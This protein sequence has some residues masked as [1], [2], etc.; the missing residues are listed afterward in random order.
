[1]RVLGLTGSVGSGKSHVSDYLSSL[2]ARIVD[3]D[4]ISH[5]LTAPGGSALPD[6]RRVF[7]DSVFHSDGTLN[8]KALAG[9][10]FSSDD[11]RSQL[12]AVIQPMILDE[13]H[14]QMEKA[15]TDQ[16]P[17]CVLD[18]PLLFEEHLDT[19]C[20]SIWCV[21]LPQELQ[22]RRI[23]ERDGCSAS[24]ALARI[25]AQMD[26]REKANRSHVVID[27]S[28]TFEETDAQVLPC[29]QRELRLSAEKGDASYAGTACQ[30]PQV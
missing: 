20:D 9:I 17:V 23:M 8:R 2:G 5:A 14:A 12:N 4:K 3:G 16:C 10:V 19:L 21:Y 11:M 25:H 15:R 1:M 6:I 26:A 13:I 22:I 29:Y 30:T 18:M 7:G 28:G 27:T 24:D